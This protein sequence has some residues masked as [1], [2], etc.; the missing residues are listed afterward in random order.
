MGAQGAVRLK[1]QFEMLETA[2]QRLGQVGPIVQAPPRDLAL[3]GL[4]AVMA[5]RGRRH[6]P[7][8]KTSGEVRF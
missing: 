4:H 6:L 5:A 8:G 7:A 2:K 3:H 1:G